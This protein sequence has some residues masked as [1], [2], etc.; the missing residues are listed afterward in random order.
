MNRRDFFKLAAVAAASPLAVAE[1]VAV[2]KL[3]GKLAIVCERGNECYITELYADGTL[4]HRVLQG[5]P[6]EEHESFHTF[7]S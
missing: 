5:K 3:I 7:F 2:P 6:W 1:G 4:R